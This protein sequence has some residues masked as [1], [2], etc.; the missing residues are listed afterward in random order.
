M[1]RRTLCTA[2]AMAGI[3]WVSALAQ[4]EYPN[5]VIRLIAPYAPG[6]TVDI[7]SRALAERL[8]RDLGQSVIVENRGGAGGTI[9]AD[10]ASKAK[11]DGYTVLFGAVHHAIAQSVYPKLGY[12]IRDLTPIGFLGRVN[13]AL[14]I[15][16]ALPAKNVRELVALL[17]AEPQRYSYATPGAGTMQHLMAEYFKNATGTQM[18]HVPYRGSSPAMV[19][20]ISGNVA[21]MFETMPS[22]LQH[23]N[24]GNVRAIAVTAKARSPHLPQVPTIAE[25]GAPNYDA[26]SWYGLYAPAKTPQAVVDRLNLAINNAFKDKAFVE[27]WVKLGADAGGG[28][29][30]ELK[31]LTVDEVSRWGE[32]ARSAKITI[33]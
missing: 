8:Q 3:P 9:G 4:S 13:H 25:S 29:P 5:Q 23:I 6:G 18:T 24:A 27:R 26:T 15:N 28:T 2:A 7:L 16:N 21:L 31:K 30:A 17:K 12:D 14:I 1:N 19:D 33:D 11:P 10:V 20:V 32:L 22:A